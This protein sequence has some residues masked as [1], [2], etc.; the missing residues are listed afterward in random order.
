[1]KKLIILSLFIPGF[2]MGQGQNKTMTYK[3]RKQ[4]TVNTSEYDKG[5]GMEAIPYALADIKPSFP[6]GKEKLGA[7]LKDNLKYP[8]PE[9]SRGIEGRVVVSFIV[10]SSGFIHSI[11]V[12]SGYTDNMNSEALR[13]IRNMPRWKPGEYR[14]YIFPVMVTLPVEFRI[15]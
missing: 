8:E 2:L 6:G 10:S 9:L 15:E 3:V 5:I 4:D 7:Y 13:L 14:N 11:S 12:F 1:M